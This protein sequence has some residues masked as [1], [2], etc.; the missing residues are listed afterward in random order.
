MVAEVLPGDKASQ[1][2]AFQAAGELGDRRGG[3]GLRRVR[4]RWVRLR[5]RCVRLRHGVL[6]GDFSTNDD[7]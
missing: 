3:I 1:V 2:S 5:F 7:W 4:L 6:L